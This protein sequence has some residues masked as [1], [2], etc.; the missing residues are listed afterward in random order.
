M[1]SVDPFQPIVLTLPSFSPSLAV[2]VIPYGLTIH[3]ILVNGDGK[4]HDLLIGP[5]NPE[6][7]GELRRFMNTIVGRYSNRIPTGDFTLEKNGITSQL[8]VDG[9]QDA[10]VQLHGGHDGFDKRVFTPVDP[11]DFSAYSLFSEAE[12]EQIVQLMPAAAIFKF[13]SPDKD[14]GYPGQLDLEVLVALVQPGSAPKSKLEGEYEL[15]S[16][17][18]VYRAKVEGE[19]G[20]KTVTPVNLTQ[21]W[22]FNLDAS[23]PSGT[24]GPTPGVTSQSLTINASDTLQLKA[25]GLATGN[26]DPTKGTPHEHKEK[27]I[28]E[29]YP[30]PGYDSFYIFER[31]PSKPPSSRV[32]LD[33]LTTLNEVASLT[34]PST[35]DEVPVELSSKDT[36]I[37]ISFETNQP[38]VQF[39]TGIGLSKES[40]SRKKIHGGSGN[41]GDGY[42]P[43]AG[44]F[45]EFHEPL[46]AWQHPWGESHGDT[47]LTS[48]ELYNN[49]TKLNVYFKRKE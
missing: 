19:G 46:A 20:K 7:H 43:K 13:T 39:Y 3:K 1:A 16:V 23:L 22:G 34:Q 48:D 35:V 45:L 32:P 36:G 38:G 24:A 2:Q 29:K 30:D 49:Y 5:E 44:A 47:L 18:I 12:K 33:S 10:D 9:N 11:S 42:E 28:G 31:Q 17:I 27:P 26:Y 14:E 25:N 6:E 21:H 41:I 15:G 37:R 8:H 40:G 4:T